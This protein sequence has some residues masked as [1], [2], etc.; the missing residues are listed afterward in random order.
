SCAHPT[1]RL[2]RSSATAD[3]G[4]RG[5]LAYGGQHAPE[6]GVRAGGDRRMSA[7][8]QGLRVEDVS[9]RFEGLTA[10]EGVSFSATPGRGLGAIGPNG[11]GKTKLF[12][13]ICGFV[14]PQ[15]GTISWRGEAL[16]RVRPHELVKQGIARTI[17]G[18]RLF[19]H[20]SV[21]E[22]VMVG[23]DHLHRP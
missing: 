23:A 12:N 9:V 7:A 20:L 16:K 3:N 13:V 4:A 10:L 1:N 18:V 19:P 8:A 5:G 14:R 15:D 21:L 17:Q 6:G 11:A 22:N 2:N